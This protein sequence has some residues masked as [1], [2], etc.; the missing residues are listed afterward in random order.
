MTETTEALRE[1]DIYLWN[2]RDPTTDN[3]SWGS[4]HCCSRIAVV[5]RGRLRD[6]Y[7]SSGDARSFGAEDLSKLELTRIGNFSELEQ[8]KEYQAD[9]YDDA[10]IVNLNHANSTSGNFYLRKGAKRSQD[11]MLAV[12]N[13]RYAEAESD[14]HTAR[15]RMEEIGKLIDQIDDGATNLHIPSWGSR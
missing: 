15:R 1:G 6:T 7:W 2:Y 9:Y 13:Q 12:A 11:K 14:F 3:R 8:A 4:Y 5:T 10:D